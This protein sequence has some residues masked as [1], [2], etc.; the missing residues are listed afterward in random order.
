MQITRKF[1]ALVNTILSFAFLFV[2]LSY[3]PNSGNAQSDDSNPSESVNT[4]AGA[5][6][7]ENTSSTSTA[8]LPSDTD[9]RI[10][11]FN[12]PHMSRVPTST[13]RNQLLLFLPGT[14][15]KPREHFAFTK[16]AAALGYHS[17]SLMYPDNLASQTKCSQSAD[18]H[19]YIKFRLAIIQGG[20]IG[21]HREITTADSIESRL[22][23]LLLYLDAKQPKEG[24]RQFLDT[25]KQIKWNLI[26]VSGGSQ[27]GGHA[28]MIAKV[29]PVARV[30]MFGS[31]KDYSF[32]FNAPSLDFDSNTKTPI[33]R[34]FSFNHVKDNGNGC[35]H[36]QNMMILK[37]IGLCALGTVNADEAQGNFKHGH[38]I[39]TDVQLPDNSKGYHGS[40]HQPFP[41]C[42]QTWKY[43]LTEPVQ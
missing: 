1:R 5:H 15:G 21:P 40:V 42:V 32:H 30:I 28:Y 38:V 11:T 12:A 29:H 18:P 27:G 16:I 36:D 31:P 6:T 37:Q 35:N 23:Q 13:P 10:T 39:T 24:W 19:A 26:A 7:D 8:T 9:S 14:G 4:S 33:S 20:V 22:R 41:V 25:K 2:S 3:C 34:M 17:I 43:M